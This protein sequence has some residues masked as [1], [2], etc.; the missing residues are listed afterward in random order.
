MVEI[1]S[2]YTLREVKQDCIVRNALIHFLTF[3]TKT[4]TWALA[5]A[6][7]DTYTNPT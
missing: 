1:F 4:G 6:D 7:A 2:I 3:D 5:L